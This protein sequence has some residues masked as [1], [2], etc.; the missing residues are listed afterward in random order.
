MQD[1]QFL[2]IFFGMLG[3]LVVLTLVLITIAAITGSGVSRKLAAERVEAIN[4]LVTE[5]IE[6]VGA[7]KVGLQQAAASDTGGGQTQTAAAEQVASGE[8]VYTNNCSACHASGA[9]GAPMIT[10]AEAWAPR[11]EKGRDTLLQHAINGFNAMPAKGGNTSLS[12]DAVA[13]AVGYM[14]EQ[15]QQ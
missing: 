6:P 10:D 12:D 7:L 14:M 3:A 11:L 9:A 5:R 2:R 4:E 15:A 13:A 1:S 8:Q